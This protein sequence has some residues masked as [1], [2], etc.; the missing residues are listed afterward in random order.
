MSTF[1]KSRLGLLCL[2]AFS[3]LMALVLMRVLNKAPTPSTAKPVEAPAAKAT[4]APPAIEE[5]DTKSP[6][7]EQ[8][9]HLERLRDVQGTAR[10]ERDRDGLGVTR[11][12][13]APPIS[14]APAPPTPEEV[15]TPTPEKPRGSVRLEGRVP[16]SPTLEYTQAPLAP[17]P[18]SA[19][20]SEPVAF[21]PYGRPIR[22]ELVF[23]IDSCM[24]ETP[25]IGLVVE[26]V[27]NNGQLVIPPG[28]EIHGIARPDRLRDRIFSARDWVLVFPR[29]DGL[30]NG[31]QLSVKGLVLDR[32]EPQPGGLTWGITDGSYGLQGDVIRS[33]ESEQVKRF[34][35]TFLSAAALT[36]QERN[37]SAR[38]TRTVANTPANAA[39]QGIASSLEDVAKEIA[40]EVEKHGVFIRVPGGKQFYFYPQ[41]SI[42]PAK[43]S[44]P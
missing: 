1:L 21:V 27:Y 28:T 5:S 22:C 11:R 33:L 17:A 10:I 6:P 13:T 2:C 31:R 42:N 44:T 37:Q 43:A 12:R 19:S 8:F 39:L 18:A 15:Q 38:G 24:E 23:T 4:A 3:V 30:P 20:E 35:A 25:L 16:L 36:L 32:I 14:P 7:L 40:R 26:P 29:T 41:Q 9:V 34:A